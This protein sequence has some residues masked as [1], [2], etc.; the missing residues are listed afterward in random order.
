MSRGALCY[1]RKI[2]NI[3]RSFSKELSLSTIVVE[4]LLSL[5]VSKNS[6]KLKKVKCINTVNGDY[7][8]F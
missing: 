2:I 8:L 4:I 3:V 1:S 7:Y 6:V 5:L